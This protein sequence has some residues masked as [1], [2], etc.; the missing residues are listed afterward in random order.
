MVQAV[1]LSQ[2]K[3]KYNNQFLHEGQT[4][5]GEKSFKSHYYNTAL[6][7]KKAHSGVAV[8][9]ILTAIVTPLY[10]ASLAMTKNSKVLT[11]STLAGFLYS[12]GMDLGCGAIVDHLRNNKAPNKNYDKTNVGEKVGGW[13]GAGF[14][15]LSVI[16][17]SS[18]KTGSRALDLISDIAAIGIGALGGKWLG[19]ISDK[20]AYEKC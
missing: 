13:L 3:P 14:T 15:T 6:Y 8:G 12:A 9:A 4:C 18:I 2:N 16:M 5:D 7:N 1:N 10:L 11:L 17:G 19:K 20:H